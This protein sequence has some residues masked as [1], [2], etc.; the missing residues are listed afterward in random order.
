MN[1]KDKI[2][3]LEKDILER[4]VYDNKLVDFELLK[5]EY[6]ISYSTCYRISKRLHLIN[7]PI[8]TINLIK[9]YH[10]GCST[11]ELATKYNTSEVNVRSLIK[12]A[13]Y[14]MR[15]NRYIYNTSYFHNV[16]TEH[17]A[18]FLGF[19]YADG[20]VSSNSMSLGVRDYDIHIL[21][22]F[23][24]ELESNKP[25]KHIYIK[26][27]FNGKSPNTVTHMVKYEMSGKNLIEDLKKY[28]IVEN[29]TK[30]IKFPQNLPNHLIRH[31]IRGYFDG[32]GCFSTYNTIT[33]KN[34][35][36]YNN[37]KY[38]VSF[39]GTI[40]FLLAVKYHI[41]KETTSKCNNVLYQRYKDRQD[42]IRSLKITGKRNVIPFLKW[43]YTDS[44]IY[45]NRKKEKANQFIM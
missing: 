12:N 24:S 33:R 8:R 27:G 19:I 20:N 36:E 25:I 42:N 30:I 29:K 39:V 13:G 32:D 9:E 1:K 22:S 6:N 37:T 43:I 41:E 17:K 11:K 16:D 3:A 15:K 2:K 45:L 31:F 4:F 18:Y 21:E 38:E 26:G 40:D 5:S 28:G 34:N 44:N 7:R 14:E 23:K 35:K 10:Q